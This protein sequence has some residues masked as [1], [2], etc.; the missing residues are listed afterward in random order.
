MQQDPQAP[1]VRLFQSQPAKLVSDF[2]NPLERWQVKPFWE[3]QGDATV[4][5]EAQNINNLRLHV[6][7]EQATLVFLPTS[8]R[9]PLPGFLSIHFKLILIWHLKLSSRIQIWPLPWVT[10]CLVFGG[11]AEGTIST[12]RQCKPSIRKTRPRLY[13]YWCTDIFLLISET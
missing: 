9:S 4:D 13:H 11:Q 2:S 3:R 6:L 10:K 8:K 12:P 7:Q 1:L 5:L